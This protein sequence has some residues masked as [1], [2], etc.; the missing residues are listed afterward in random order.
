MKEE[1]IRI[2]TCVS[3]FLH[4]LPLLLR[5]PDGAEKTDMDEN[6]LE[7]WWWSALAIPCSTAG[8][9]WQE[10]VENPI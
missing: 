2:K 7:C 3:V 8:A 10:Y 5:S 6:M 9:L 4:E 1:K